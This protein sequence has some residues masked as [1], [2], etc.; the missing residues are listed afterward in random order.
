MQCN[1]HTEHIVQLSS[2]GVA[3]AYERGWESW[4]DSARR[5]RFQ[6]GLVMAMSWLLLYSS[7]PAGESVACSSSFSKHHVTTREHSDGPL[8]K[9]VLP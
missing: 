6:N 1:M 5:Q 7:S 4:A 8:A 2:C 3:S 9:R